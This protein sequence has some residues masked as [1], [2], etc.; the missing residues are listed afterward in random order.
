MSRCMEPKRESKLKVKV[1]VSW[2]FQ[3]SIRW[4]YRQLAIK[5]KC[6]GIA[7]HLKST[8]CHQQ[9]TFREKLKIVSENLINWNLWDFEELLLF[10]MTALERVA[11]II[12]NRCVIET[13][14]ERW[15]SGDEISL[16]IMGKRFR[17]PARRNENWWR[18]KVW[19]RCWSSTLMTPNRIALG[20]N[21]SHETTKK[22]HQKSFCSFLSAAWVSHSSC[23]AH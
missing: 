12:R 3:F 9:R 6:E 13:S 1:R 5:V 17:S 22:F 19:Q 8:K 15:T 10:M 11:E 2:F 20:C 7:L 21:T 18:G 16:N 23:A 14:S 4:R